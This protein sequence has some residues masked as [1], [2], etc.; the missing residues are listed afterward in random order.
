MKAATVLVFVY[1]FCAVFETTESQTTSP[2]SIP[3]AVKSNTSCDECL[4]NVTCLWC[5]STKQCIDYPV[6]NVLPFH[7]G[8]PLNDARW[9]ACWVNFQT[10]IITMSVIAAVILIAI[11]VCCCCRCDRIGFRNQREDAR[12]EQEK[13]AR[14]A[15]H[16]ERRT[17]MQMRHDVIRQKYGL[18][19]NN[20]YSR[21]D[22]A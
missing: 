21:M 13:R 10:L 8:C 15:R 17:E 4:K 3:C 12:L 14:E 2:S 19:K 16:K 11:L 22:N 18:T 20:P 9:A 1:I 7:T 6:R 5:I